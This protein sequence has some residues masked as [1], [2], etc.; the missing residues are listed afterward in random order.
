MLKVL[1][2]ALGELGYREKG[3]NITKYSAYFNSYPDFYNGS[4]GD[5]VSWG[6]EWCDCFNDWSFCNAYGVE[7]ARQMLYQSKKSAGAGCKFS[8]QFYRDAGRFDKKPQEG[9]QIFFGPV[10]NEYHTGIVTR[11]QDNIVWTVEGNKNNCVCECRYRIDDPSIAGYGH[12]NYSLVNETPNQTTTQNNTKQKEQPVMITVPMLK[13]GSKGEA[14]KSLQILLN[15]Y[16]FTGK[17]G[18]KLTVDGD[19]GANTEFALRAFQRSA[20][21]T[22]DGICGVKTWT[23]LIN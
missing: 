22:P 8:A 4:K 6:C 3:K 17:N 11:V 5:G 12:P 20:G 7:T 13:L 14:V 18:K 19:F 2:I 10:G 21:L 23:L 9:D 15:G 1:E 16:N